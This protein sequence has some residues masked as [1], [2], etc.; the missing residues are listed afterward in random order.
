[1]KTLLVTIL[2]FLSFSC[3][4]THEVDV[5]IIGGGASG[6]TAGIQAAR[7]GAHTL[8]I[9]E[10]T[11]LGG[12]LTAAGVSAI[13]GNHKLPSGLWGEFREKL[14]AYYGHEDNLRTGWVSKVLFEP[15]VRNEIWKKLA[16]E[17]KNLDIWYQSSYETVRRDQGY[18]IVEGKKKMFLSGSKR[19]Y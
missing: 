5:L 11:W 18:W 13:D 9:E 7:L 19:K 16:A 3:V 10:Y 14:I 15:S 12:M 1:M 4:K 8:I 17:E 6:T 2:C